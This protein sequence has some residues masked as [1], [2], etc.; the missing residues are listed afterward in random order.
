MDVELFAKNVETIC[1]L[2]EDL[3]MPVSSLMAS[4]VSESVQDDARLDSII[5]DKKM[6]DARALMANNLGD[7]NMTWE[8]QFLLCLG[9]CS[10][11][12]MTHVA[13]RLAMANMGT[14]EIDQLLAE[15]R[16][17]INDPDCD[18]K[19]FEAFKRLMK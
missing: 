9:L 10:D 8:E 2:L 16:D 3:Q 19:M 18:S 14:S 15:A 6:V 17:V 7:Q 1:T 4:M 11:V 13:G 5:N 12:L